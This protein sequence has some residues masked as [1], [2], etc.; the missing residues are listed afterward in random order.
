M[1]ARRHDLYMRLR[2]RQERK[3]MV[4]HTQHR[5]R[6]AACSYFPLRFAGLRRRRRARQSRRSRPRKF[7]SNIAYRRFDDEA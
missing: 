1:M 3:D 5:F 6:H 2:I 4:R 7:S